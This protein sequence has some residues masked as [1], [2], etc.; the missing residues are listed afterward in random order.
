MFR[1]PFDVLF[2]YMYWSMVLQCRLGKSL[3]IV[4][5]SCVF[6]CKVT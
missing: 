5:L 6:R 4:A 3:S 1:S 2:Q